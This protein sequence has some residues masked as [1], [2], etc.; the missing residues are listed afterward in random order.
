MIARKPGAT[1]YGQFTTCDA[2]SGA[3]DADATP[4]AAAT[5][6]GVDDA[7]FVLTVT[8]L[9][10]GRYKV[11]GT[12][13]A[14]YAI[15]DVVQ[16]SVAATVNGVAGVAIVDAF[17]IGDEIGDLHAVKAALLNATEYDIAAGRKTVMDDDGETPLVVIDVTTEDEG[18]TVVETPQ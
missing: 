15:G 9:A 1:Y 10:T 2:S 17:A 7:A 5:R 6:N 18:Q 13:P 8:N 12:V 4:V 16:I 14:G 3:A 11:T